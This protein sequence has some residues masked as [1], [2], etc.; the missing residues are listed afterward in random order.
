M[1]FRRPWTLDLS[2]QKAF[3]F[4]HFLISDCSMTS[5]YA[6]SALPSWAFLK[7]PLNFNFQFF[8]SEKNERLADIALIEIR[9]IKSSHI[10][11]M[12]VHAC[13]PFLFFDTK[14]SWDRMPCHDRFLTRKVRKVISE[15]SCSITTSKL[16]ILLQDAFDI[17]SWLGP[18]AKPQVS[19]APQI[20]ALLAHICSVWWA[21]FK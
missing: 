7:V 12:S 8:T 14:N 17:K 1:L 19:S 4:K 2:F 9:M 13:A 20:L 3:L 16:S 5:F 10:S 21:I 6:V 11:E 18:S 15:N